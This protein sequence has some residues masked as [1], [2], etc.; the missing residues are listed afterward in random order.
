MKG[1]TTCR[2]LSTALS[3]AALIAVMAQPAWAQPNLFTNGDFEA[4][5]E[6][7]ATPAGDFIIPGS[8]VTGWRTFSVG[9][10]GGQMT[11]TAAAGRTGKGVEIVRNNATGDSAMDL[12]DA[13]LRITLPAEQRIYKFTVDARDGG[14]FGTPQ[15]VLGAQFQNPA[16]NRGIGFNPTADWQT[17][18]LT[19]RSDGNPQMSARMDM[20]AAA[21][22]SAHLDNARLVDAT[23]LVNR[24]VNGGFEGSSSGLPNWRF[25]S[26]GGTA[27]SVALSQDAATGSN[28]ALLTVTADAGTTDRDIGLDIDPFRLAVLEGEE[29]QFSFA[30]KKTVDADTRIRLEVAGFNAA[31]VYTGSV[32][33]TM[34]NPGMNAYESFLTSAM[35]PANVAYV[36]VSFRVM[37]PDTGLRGVGGYLIDDV[38]VMGVPE[39]ASLLLIAL[40]AV[41]S[42][43]RR[44]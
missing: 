3:L 14:P 21:G 38:S 23:L 2:R 15:V 34:W 13:T 12:D 44:H 33:S 11:V 26:V 1:G 6:G 30:A 17:F 36:N 35:V 31:G 20:G 37:Q 29:L 43:K 24:M 7:T 19:A 41:V 28:A 4:D 39:P 18:G 42:L 40:G 25:F 27:G 16:F 10:A 32:S 5:V 22:R 8:V 9:A